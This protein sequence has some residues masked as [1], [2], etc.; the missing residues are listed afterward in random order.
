MSDTTY[1]DFK[2]QELAL[3][4]EAHAATRAKDWGRLKKVIRKLKR[5]RKEKGI[6]A[7]QT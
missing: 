4:N 3:K 5:L 6:Y 2:A 7:S 1:D